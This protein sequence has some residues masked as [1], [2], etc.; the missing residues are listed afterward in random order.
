MIYKKMLKKKGVAK[1]YD[2]D[3]HGPFD[4]PCST[5]KTHG[6]QFEFTFRESP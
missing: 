4:M 1:D 5:L 3:E 2:G 6:C